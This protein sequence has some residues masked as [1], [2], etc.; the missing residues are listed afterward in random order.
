[1][2]QN[3]NF[4]TSYE[5]S[6]GLE[7]LVMHS[8]LS[9]Y[10]A[11][12]LTRSGNILYLHVFAQRA[13]MCVRLVTAGH[14]TNIRLVRRVHVTVFLTIAAVRKPPIT[15]TVFAFK[16]LLTWKKER[17]KTDSNNVSIKYRIAHCANTH[18]EIV[19]QYRV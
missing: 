4:H 11:L 8:H 14:S 2:L 5:T 12:W 18:D 19:D 9:I 13:R 3:R 1:M 15:V 10:Q 16:R 6:C 17:K 7:V